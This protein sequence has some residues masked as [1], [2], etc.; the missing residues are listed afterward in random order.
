MDGASKGAAVQAAGAGLEAA[1]TGNAAEQAAGE[2]LDSAEVF[3]AGAK[4]NVGDGGAASEQACGMLRLEPRAARK[5]GKK[6]SKAST[7]HPCK[8]FPNGIDEAK[9][10]RRMTAEEPCNDHVPGSLDVVSDRAGVPENATNWLQES[11]RKAV[12]G[13]VLELCV[14]LE[15]AQLRLSG[16][17]MLELYF[18]VQDAFDEATFKREDLNKFIYEFVRQRGYDKDPG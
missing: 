14:G 7:A 13:T 16:S 17:A 11:P 5:G 4:H 12:L 10:L 1:C 6:T 3:G 2:G 8:A 18:A 15:I 9:T